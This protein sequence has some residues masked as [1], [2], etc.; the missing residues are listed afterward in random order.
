MMGYHNP[1][2]DRNH[3]VDLC[4]HL[5]PEK[6]PEWGKE[7]Q[8][9]WQADKNKSNFNYYLLLVMLWMEINDT[10]FNIVPGCIQTYFQ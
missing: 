8:A 5:H 4:W 6:A 9:K 2:Q 7:A 3:S 10:K 1:K